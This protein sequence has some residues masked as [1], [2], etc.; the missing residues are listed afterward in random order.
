MKVKP[1]TIQTIE[2]PNEGLI[3][4]LNQ[5]VLVFCMNYFYFGKLVGVNDTCIKIEKCYIIY[6]TGSFNDKTFKDKQ[7]IS[8]EWYLQTAT[9]ESFGK[10]PKS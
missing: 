4:L 3:S 9:I 2:V 7:F 10:S 6:E 1:E 8:E 5:N